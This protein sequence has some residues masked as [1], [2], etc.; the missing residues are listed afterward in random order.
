VN[1]G[2]GYTAP[3]KLVGAPWIDAQQLTD[4]LN[5]LNLPGV[6]FTPAYYK[7]FYYHFSG[8]NCQGVRIHLMNPREIRPCWV[9]FNIMTALRDLYPDKFNFEIPEN[10]RRI[11][12]FDKACGTDQVRKDFTAGL[13]AEQ[14]YKNWQSNQEPFLQIRKKYLIY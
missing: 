7:P 6:K 2:V 3:F 13:S 12:M 10:Q 14:M 8:E 9:G 11:D 1:I 4:Y 5:E